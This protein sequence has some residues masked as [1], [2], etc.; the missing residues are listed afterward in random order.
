MAIG[1]VIDHPAHARLLAPLMREMSTP[2][3]VI[4][5]CDRIE[6]RSM[7]EKS[8]G[9]LPRRKTVWVPRPVGKNR[10]RKAFK[11]Y[12]ISKLALK[13][14]NLVVSIGAPIELRAAPKKSRRIYITDTEVNHTAHKFANPTDIV[15]PTH[16]DEDLSGNLL[17]KKAVIH[18]ISGLHGHVHLQPRLRPKNVSDPP[19]ILVR[20]LVGGGIHDAGEIVSIPEKWLEGLE[21]IYANENEY[22]GNPWK[23]DEEIS[24]VD[25]VITQSVTL[26]SE[27]VIQGVP[28]LLVSKAKRGFLNRLTTDGYPIFIDENA[29]DS[30][31]ASWLAGLHLLDELEKIDWPDVKSELLDILQH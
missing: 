18:R 8:D 28:A 16:F 22:S 13:H 14:S 2:D 1:W 21:V 25:G 27:A 11:R 17:K 29:Q 19:K 10:Y 9:Y 20:K 23:L 3:D 4:I 30:T 6:V 7:I 5:A 15:I 26:A 31:Y 24:K 12:R